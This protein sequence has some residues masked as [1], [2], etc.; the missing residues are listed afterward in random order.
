MRGHQDLG[1]GRGDDDQIRQ[2]RKQ[3][4]MQT[5]FRFVEDDRAGESCELQITPPEGF[6]ADA[7]RPGRFYGV[8]TR[9]HQRF[10]LRS[11]P[12]SPDWSGRLLVSSAVENDA[13]S[14]PQEALS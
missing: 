8:L 5:R 4:G 1:P 3:I 11:A 7:E 12:Y 2:C 9:D 14:V 13:S 6:I 10:S